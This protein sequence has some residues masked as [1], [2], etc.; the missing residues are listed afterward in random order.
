MKISK[1]VTKF[2]INDYVA[3]YHSLRMKPV[4]L[5]KIESIELEKAILEN[6][7]PMLKEDVKE[8]LQKYFI[9]VET[10]EGI[11]EKVRKYV[12][13]P[14]ISVAYFVLTE[15][16]NLACKYCFLGNSD[17]TV[18]KISK[19][20]MSFKVAEKALEFFSRQTMQDMD[21]FYDDKEIIFYGGE[22]LI[23]FK[24]LEYTVL[25]SKY[26][27][28]NHLISKKLKFSLISNGTLLDE[29][30][31]KFLKDNNI[32]VSISIDGAS[33]LENA[34]RIDKSGKNIYDKVIK[35]LILAKKM[36]LNFGLSITLSEESIDN[37]DG[38]IE[39]IDML[40]VNSIC[41]NILLKVK[42]V[43]IEENYYINATNF[44]IEFY[45]K[46]MDKGIYEERFMRKLKAFIESKIYFSDCAATSGSQVVIT[47]DGDVGI[48]HGTM[49]NREFFIGNVSDSNLIV[50][51]NKDVVRWSKLSPIF[52][53]ECMLCPALGICGGGCPINAMRSSKYKNLEAI[54]KAFC[55]HAK[56][57]LKYLIEKLLFF[58]LEN[59][60]K[61]NDN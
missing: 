14:Y 7:K 32:S 21:Q 16:C 39:F 53:S 33:E 29:N 49:E 26:Y 59:Q 8:S 23:N 52:K 4:F 3:Y 43:H 20:N 51:N 24:T 55:I 37:I 47:P 50:A 56:N 42:G 25:R 38:L 35:N 36:G 44:I 22:P 18:Q 6:R 27:Q 60:S 40:N 2:Y 12:P 41:F 11:I 45:E 28:E 10:D 34:N 19:E 1:Y 31:I 58:T 15:Q 61:G 30:K 9:V 13:K 54:D 48:C 17:I 57:M 46:T 5:S